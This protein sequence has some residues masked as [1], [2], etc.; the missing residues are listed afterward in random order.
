M[1]RLSVTAIIREAYDFTLAN[2]GAI[3]GLI[4]LPMV[5]LTVGQF[6][7]N[8]H[9]G[10]QVNE[11]VAAGNPAAAGPAVLALL[12]F[13][14]V[15]LALT[16]MMMVSVWW[17]RS[18]AEA[19]VDPW[20]GGVGDAG[21]HLERLSCSVA[22]GGAG[23]ACRG[24]LRIGGRAGTLGNSRRFV[25]RDVRQRYRLERDTAILR[26]VMTGMESG[27]DEPAQSLASLTSLR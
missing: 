11:A 10:A 25:Q 4:W 14:L 13:L 26:R 15:Q 20:D 3:I 17:H 6:F 27:S 1:R 8:Q 24:A 21:G 22:P 23:L 2:L 7:V 19:S 12:S 16:A 18:P 5:L 9:Y